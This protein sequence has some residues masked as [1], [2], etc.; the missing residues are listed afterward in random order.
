MKKILI[1]K[2][3]SGGVEVTDLEH[4]PDEGMDRAIFLATHCQVL[5]P[6]TINDPV[7]LY[8]KDADGNY[9]YAQKENLISWRLTERSSLPSREFRNAWHD[10]DPTE[11]VDVCPIRAKEIKANQLRVL[12]DPKLKA[13]DVEY[14]KADE[15]GDA[16]KK[17][18]IATRKQVLR[19]VTMNLPTTV[20]ALGNFMPDCLK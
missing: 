3:K 10:E 15:Q 11:T 12:R 6:E 20:E 1:A 17:Q 5:D 13:L 4:I 9:V 19:D 7:R 8:L 18:E 2:T 14:Q 16:A